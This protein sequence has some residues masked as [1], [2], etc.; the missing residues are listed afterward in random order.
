LGLIKAYQKL[1]E[2]NPEIE[3]PD[4]VLGGKPGY[5]YKKLRKRY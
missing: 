3:I 5:G 2:D 4:L 1:R